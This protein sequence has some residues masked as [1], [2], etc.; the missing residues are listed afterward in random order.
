MFEFVSPVGGVPE[1]RG[2]VPVCAAAPADAN[3]KT[4]PSHLHADFI[5]FPDPLVSII[6][7]SRPKA[8]RTLHV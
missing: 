1:S 8:A 4:K 3:A 2:T 6:C 7:C 5:I